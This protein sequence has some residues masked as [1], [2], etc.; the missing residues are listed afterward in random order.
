MYNLAYI[1]PRN[2][3]LRKWYEQPGT[4]KTKNRNYF[5]AF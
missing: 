1:T 2:D 3:R 4:S 5:Q